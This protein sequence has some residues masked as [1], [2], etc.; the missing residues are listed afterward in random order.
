MAAW[1]RD[2]K[3]IERTVSTLEDILKRLNRGEEI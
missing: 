2:P 1:A 3:T